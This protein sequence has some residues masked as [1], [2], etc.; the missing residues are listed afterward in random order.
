M[1]DSDDEELFEALAEPEDIP[2]PSEPGPARAPKGTVTNSVEFMRVNNL[3][4]RILD[5][6]NVEDVTD[7]YR[8]PSGRMR[9][10]PAQSAALTEAA[11]AD[12]LFAPLG[13]GSGKSVCGL[14]LPVAMNS[15]NAVILVPPALKK[16]LITEVNTIYRRNFV[17]PM[18]NITVVAYTELSSAKKSEILDEIDPDLIIAD[19]CNALA[20]RDAART[21]RFLRFARTHPH[22]RFAFMSGTITSKSITQYAHLIELALRKNS[23][24]PNSYREVQDWAGALDVKP[25]YVMSPGILMKLC[26][27]GEEVRG[28]YRRRLVETLGVVATSESAIGTSLII[29]RIAPTVPP[30]VEDALERARR[31]W[32]VGQDE[33]AS[34]LDMARSLRQ[35]ACGMYLRWVWP[36]DEIDHAW[37]EARSAWNKEV[38]SI[39]KR[40][41]LHLDSPLLCALAAERAHQ[42]IKTAG[43][44]WKSETWE[45]WREQ[46]NKKPPPSEPVWISDYLVKHAAAWG[47]SQ[48]V[49]AIIWYANTCVGEAIAKE[50]GLPVYGAGTDSPPRGT[51]LFVASMAVHGTGKNYQWASSN[52]ITAMPS[53]GNLF[54]Q[55]VGR[56]HRPG[57]QADEVIVDW[58]GQTPEVIAAMESVIA[59]A[60][61]VEQS[62][63]QRQKILYATKLNS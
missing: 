38:R 33:I 57:Q 43:K 8:Q 27:P 18:A 22:C 23:P 53:S 3:P 4:R 41:I 44:V 21:K 48:K 26:A 5:Y 30:E 62:T 55:V 14:L 52:L 40:S 56:T 36:N 42:G 9:L 63:G 61:Y 50:L 47:R 15:K 45:A 35:L 49:P 31:T 11:R 54:E 1:A 10:W 19:E 32:S 24:L 46:K 16:Q 25:Q 2:E 20:N 29:K 51:K 60:E 7:L 34:P 13:V 39:L 6:N 17:I 37:L 12:G 28:G 59:S 58:Y